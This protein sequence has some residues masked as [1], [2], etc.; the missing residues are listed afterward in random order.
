MRPEDPGTSGEVL[1]L[2][3][4]AP[5]DEKAHRQTEPSGIIR[6]VQTF[7]FGLIVT[8]ILACIVLAVIAY[9]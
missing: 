7:F 6:A 2:D 4:I 1:P 3:V 5:A 8:A 9:R